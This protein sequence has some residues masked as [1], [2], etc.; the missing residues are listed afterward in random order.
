MAGVNVG[1]V[2][3]LAETDKALLVL[4]EADASQHWIPKSVIDPA[5]MLK[6]GDVEDLVIMEWFAKKEGLV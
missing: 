6:Q 1:Q 4:L 3:V 2:E 5:F